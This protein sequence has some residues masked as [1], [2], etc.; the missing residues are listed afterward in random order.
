MTHLGPTS[1]VNSSFSV[2]FYL[3]LV[4]I[5]QDQ[6]P[7]LVGGCAGALGHWELELSQVFSDLA[8]QALRA[9]NLRVEE[10]LLCERNLV[11]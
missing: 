8:G 1:F 4:S 2:R 6:V 3:D 5:G 7:A 10:A 9:D 11:E